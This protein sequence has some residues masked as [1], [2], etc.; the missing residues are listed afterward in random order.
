MGTPI[1]YHS[2]E[3]R[4]AAARAA[5]A[6][7]REANLEKH[8]AAVKRCQG[9][10]EAKEKHRIKQLEYAARNRDRERERAAK[11]RTENPERARA[12]KRAYYL[13]NQDVVKAAVYAYRRRNPEKYLEYGRLYKAAKRAGGGR[14]SNGCVRR[15]YERQ[16]GLCVACGGILSILGF[17]LDHIHPLSKGGRHCD[18]N[19]QL[20]CPTC[21]RRKSDRD[22]LSFMEMMEAER[23]DR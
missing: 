14:L 8:R 20:L 23:G 11:W 10:P 9:R 21:N 3:E 15:L 16:N 22:F 7:W 12:S 19:V 5:S 13:S 2:E 18:E 17:H 1:K 6:R 4:R